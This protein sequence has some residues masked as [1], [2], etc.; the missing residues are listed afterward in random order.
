MPWNEQL[1]PAPG[2]TPKR[3]IR[4]PVGFFVSIFWLPCCRATSNLR[5]KEQYWK[6]RS[7]NESRTINQGKP[8]TS[9]SDVDKPIHLKWQKLQRL[10]NP[11]P[12]RAELS[13]VLMNI[14]LHSFDLLYCCER[15]LSKCSVQWLKGNSPI[16]P[17]FFFRVKAKP[18]SVRVPSSQSKTRKNE[19]NK[20]VT[21][22]WKQ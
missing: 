2:G 19:N 4:Y 12:T 6:A 7:V 16:E 17:I 20:E 8:G 22:H 3:H 10:N 21:I 13:P 5:L 11:C 9:D 18:L 1:V 15:S 14:F